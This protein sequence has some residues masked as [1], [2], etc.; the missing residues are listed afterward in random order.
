MAWTV[1]L[2]SRSVRERQG[3]VFQEDPKAG[4]LRLSR[5]TARTNAGP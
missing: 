3:T 5:A 2:S 4:Q 1:P